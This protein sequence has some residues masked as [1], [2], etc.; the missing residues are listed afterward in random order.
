MLVTPMNKPNYAL[1]PITALEQEA[2]LISTSPELTAE[3]APASP[4]LRY[5]QQL[6]QEISANRDGSVATY[7]PEL[8]RANPDWFG[9]CL[10]TADGSVY[11]TGDCRLPFTIQSIS[12]PFVYG[13]ALEDRS[14]ADVLARVGVEP[15]G[16]AFNAISLEPGSGRPRNPMINA[17]AIASTG[18]VAGKTPEARLRRVVQSFSLFAGRNLSIDQTVY[19]S[20]SET[21]HRNRAIGHML[22]NF[23]IL[24]EA[25]EPVVDQYF[26]QCSIAVTCRDLAVMGAT[27]ANQGVNPLTQRRAIRGEYVESVLSVMASCGMYDYAGEWLY[28]VGMPAKSG[29]AGGLLAVLPGQLGI[30]VFSPPLDARGNSVRGIEVCDRLSRSFNLH[31]FNV[32]LTSRSVIRLRFNAAEVSSSRLRSAEEGALLRRSGGAIQLFQLQGSLVFSTGEVLL[33]AALEALAEAQSFILDMKHVLEVDESASRLLYQ[34]H[35]DLAAANKRL[36]LS[37]TAHLP[38]LRR[39]LK[40]K[41][42]ERYETD[43]LVFGDN[44]LALEWCENRWLERRIPARPQ[45]GR[46]PPESYDLFRGLNPEEIAVLTKLLAPRSYPPG[47]VMVQVG[48]EAREI[49]LLAQGSATITIPLANGTR[50]RVGVFSPGMSFGE[51]ALLDQ[52]PRSAEVVAESDVE[53]HLLGQEDFERLTETHPRIKITL[54]HNMACGLARLLRKTTREASVFDY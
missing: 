33:K 52:A 37:R 12:K 5:L 10:V 16:D 22:R 34:L 53:C 24:T 48:A 9:I 23:D 2:A 17:G 6:H 25:P 31:L 13:M 38:S 35:T 36:V 43:L 40:A 54:L 18:L 21:G 11:E 14:R 47:E 20:E 7:I 41:L 27:L 50:R 15:T 1:S 3:C 46:V 45:P 4:I 39:Y 29:V 30:G 19:A 49:F 44:D 28:R 26:R 32:P 42:G 51:V 8:A